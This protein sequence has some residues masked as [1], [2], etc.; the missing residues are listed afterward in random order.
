MN[1]S[2][3]S[4]RL[5][6]RV[7]EIE[8]MGRE[9]GREAVEDR[10]LDAFL[11]GRRL[12]DQIAGAQIGNRHGGLDAAHGRGLGLGG[13]LAARNLTFDVAVDGG[14]G[15]GQPL[16]A[17]VVHQDVIARQGEDMG[18]PVAH[19][20]GA[21]DSHKLNGHVFPRKVGHHLTSAL[22]P[23]Q[24]RCAAAKAP[25]ICAKPAH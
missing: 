6:S 10:L 8:G 20:P 22:P 18:N 14:D 7:M 23:R 24:A 19:L 15:L 11:F 25:T 17:D 5:A 3:R 12:D 4:V 16:G 1:F 21:H 13:D 9:I 2:G